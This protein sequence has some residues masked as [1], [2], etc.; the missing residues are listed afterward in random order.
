MV[1]LVEA[2]P[3][4]LPVWDETDDF[5]LGR[6]SGVSNETIFIPTDVPVEAGMKSVV[7]PCFLITVR[8]G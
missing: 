3:G 5:L 7:T 1:D 4:V 2:E 6:L 8:C